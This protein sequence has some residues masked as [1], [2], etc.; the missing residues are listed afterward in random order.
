MSGKPFTERK[1][2]NVGFVIRKMSEK[3][4][5][6]VA[7]ISFESGF[8]SWKES[9]YFAELNRET[10]FSYVAENPENKDEVI[11]FIMMRPIK[12]DAEILNVAVKKKH[13]RLGVAKKLLEIALRKLKSECFET[14]WLEVR[15][16]NSRA[17]MLYRNMG[18]RLT[19]KRKNYYSNPR[20]D[21][22]L[23]CFKL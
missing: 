4:V 17:I 6:S 10:S 3:D 23:M 2:G 15:E 7:R 16:S 5:I 20:E 18:F 9:D 14:I 11:G 21:A 19:E 13:R 22:F 12:P 1:V 8:H